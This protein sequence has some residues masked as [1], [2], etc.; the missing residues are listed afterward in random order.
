MWK[1]WIEALLELVAPRRC[2]A[3]DH[4]EV[5]H[6]ET[7]C[8]AC[9]PLVSATRGAHADLAAFV[10]GGPLADAVVA[11]KSPARLD[12]VAPMA[13][14]YARASRRFA[15]QVDVVVPIPSH[16]AS[17]R[18]RG[19]DPVAALARA[20]AHDLG[21]PCD[22]RLLVRPRESTPQFALEGHAR[23][24]NVRGAFRAGAVDGRRVLL[25]D[26]VRTT[27]A[28][29][30]EAS[31]VLRAAGAVTVWPFALAAVDAD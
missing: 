14:L 24:E 28:T 30:G 23:R 1:P 10:Y 5:E 26:D 3:C 8:E 25:V 31:S 27:G 7:F 6:E 20:A 18:R 11:M 29:L 21:V 9:A 13:H 16:R 22:H 2:P 19:F 4:D 17:L 15:R 12:A